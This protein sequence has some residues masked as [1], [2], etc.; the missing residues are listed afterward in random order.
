MKWEGS[1]VKNHQPDEY[2]TVRQPV[3]GRVKEAAKSGHAPGKSGHLA[4]EHVEKIGNNQR[5][6]SG[7]EPTHAKKDAAPDIQCDTDYR[8]DVGIDV[9]EGEPAH[10]GINDS[11]SAAPNA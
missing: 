8:Q 7:E 9:A 5:N 4:I 11:L 2:D 6:A 10:H 3:Q 1:G